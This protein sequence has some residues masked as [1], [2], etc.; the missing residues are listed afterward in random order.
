M[1]RLQPFLV[2]A[3]DLS[4][5]SLLL[6]CRSPAPH[7]VAFLAQSAGSFRY[8]IL[9]DHFCYVE[10]QVVAGMR[11]LWSFPLRGIYREILIASAL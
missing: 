4:I 2:R 7:I 6:L 10:S 5:Y 3:L 9:I 1:Y 11:D 8:E